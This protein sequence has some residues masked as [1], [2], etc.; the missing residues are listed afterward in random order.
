MKGIGF[1]ELMRQPVGFVCFYESGQADR[2]SLT[3]KITGA[4]ARTDAKIKLTSIN[5]FTSDSEPVFLVKVEVLKTGRD[6]EPVGP[7]VSSYGKADYLYKGKSLP[8]KEI[9]ELAGARYNTLY[10]KLKRNKRNPGDDV[11]D[12]AKPE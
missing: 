5:G 7:K 1:A 10:Q 3:Q 6:P 11:T 8:L 12:L 9:A 2:R 4:A